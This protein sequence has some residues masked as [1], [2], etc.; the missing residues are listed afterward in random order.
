VVFI[1]NNPTEVN[2]STGTEIYTIPVYVNIIRELISNIIA[3]IAVPLFFLISGYLLYIKEEKFV[4]VIKKRSQTILL[5]YML[6]NIL[7]VLFFYTAQSFSFTKPYFATV[8]IRNFDIMDWLGVFT[9]KSGLFAIKGYPLV[10]Q[11]WFLRDLFIL[12]VLFVGIKKLIDR[13][14]FGIL[15]LLFA[16]WTSSINIYILSTEALL[17]FALGYYIVKYSLD[18]KKLDSVRIYDVIIIYIITIIAELSFGEKEP[19]MHKINII[20]GSILFIKLTYYFINDEKL[21]KLL[22]RLEK[23]AF[24]V[25]AIHGIALAIMQKLSVKIIPMHDGWLLLQYFG[26]TIIGIIIFVIIGIIL[27]KIF[28]KMYAIL[29][30]GRI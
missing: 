27:Q 5:P 25:Y 19:T 6:W 23:H 10:Y 15:I 13:F 21:Y 26:V 20:I 22:A 17:F 12:N 8:I 28:P 3:R 9:G 11:F 4:T 16:L 1:H 2:F 29:T 24:F 7:A 14:P 18:Y 30:G